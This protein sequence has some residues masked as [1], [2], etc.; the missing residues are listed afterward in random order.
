MRLLMRTT[1]FVH[2]VVIDMILRVVVADDGDV[3]IVNT[4]VLDLGKTI[5]IINL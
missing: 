4:L 3:D 2:V 5:G 1:E